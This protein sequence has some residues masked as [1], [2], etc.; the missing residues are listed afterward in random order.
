LAT[1]WPALMHRRMTHS[2]DSITASGTAWCRGRP[3]SHVSCL[4]RGS[5]RRPGLRRHRS[6]QGS[7]SSDFIRRP[8]LTVSQRT[9]PQHALA[10]THAPDRP[11]RTLQRMVSI[12]RSAGRAGIGCIR[13]SCRSWAPACV[14]V[15]KKSGRASGS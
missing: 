3:H 10:K 8:S 1:L 9:R 4:C 12:R 11:A 5:S 14:A 7:R 6:W 2:R 13:V 15:W